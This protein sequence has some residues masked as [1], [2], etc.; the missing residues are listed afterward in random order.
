[1]L[2]R[3]IGILSIAAMLL[4]NA[5]IFTRDVLPRWLPDDAPPSDAQLLAPDERREVQVGIYDALGRQVGQSWTVA[6]RSTVG[7][8][9]SVRTTTVL[10]GLAL[11]GGLRTPEVRIES[12]ASYGPADNRID[13]VNLRLYGLG[14]PIQLNGQAMPTAEFACTWRV[15]ADDGSFLLDSKAPA[16]LGDVIRPFDRLPDLYVGQTWRLDLLD[17]LAQIVPDLDRHGLDLEP[18]LIRVTRRERISHAG[19]DVDAY[20]VEGNNTRAWVAEDGRVLRQEVRLPLIGQLVLLDEVFSEDER[21]TVSAS[22][23]SDWH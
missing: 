1:M 5:A 8:V 20:V 14:L 7:D 11:P 21:R 13:E 9:V 10:R 17:P 3:W 16:A 23:P 4:A 6:Q 19:R 2:N 22:V 18:I 15:G 12:D